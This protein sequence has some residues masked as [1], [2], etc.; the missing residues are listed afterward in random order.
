MRAADTK[1]STTQYTN[2]GKNANRRSALPREGGERA[3]SER[4]GG[5]K[6]AGVDFPGGLVVKESACLMQGTQV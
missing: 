1:C 6:S 5:I 4:Q 2:D 3:E